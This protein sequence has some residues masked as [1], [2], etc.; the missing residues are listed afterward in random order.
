MSWLVLAAGAWWLA[1]Q[2]AF[3]FPTPNRLLS[4][5][6]RR[7]MLR[8]ILRN[9]PHDRRAR[10]ELGD[11][12]AGARQFEGVREVLR[13]NIDAGDDDALLAF[14]W[15]ISSAR[16]GDVEGSE[17]AFD[18]LQRLDATF[19]LGAVDLERGRA[20]LLRGD[21]AGAK[22]ALLDFCAQRP[23]TV[24]GKVL[25]SRALAALGDEQG[26]ARVRREAWQDFVAAPR[27]RKRVER[28]WAYRANPS[29]IL[30]WVA[31]AIGLLVVLAVA[32]SG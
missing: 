15:G 11:L 24:E 31:A 4:K 22:S 29:R 18:A 6:R 17:R 21:A 12:L 8:E 3:D 2:V 1:S 28:T 14:L 16:V 27:F 5:W 9:N 19:R 10:L 30:L 20:R 7:Q 32:S 23:G 13:P 26:A 25:L